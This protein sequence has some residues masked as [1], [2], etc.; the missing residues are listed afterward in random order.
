MGS[1]ATPCRENHA[2]ARPRGAENDAAKDEVTLSTHAAA[3]HER[4]VRRI[5]L[6]QRVAG[7]RWLRSVP[8]S[9]SP[10]RSVRLVHATPRQLDVRDACRRVLSIK[11]VGER[12]SGSGQAAAVPVACYEIDDVPKAKKA[13]V[14]L[15][16]GPILWLR[17]NS[18]PLRWTIVAFADHHTVL[19]YRSTMYLIGEGSTLHHVLGV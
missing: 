17:P 4:L 2:R 18:L 7:G 16:I 5:A 13:P 3:C 1:T 11:D 10:S 6:V 9:S 8:C 19:Y 14:V 12:Q 15:N